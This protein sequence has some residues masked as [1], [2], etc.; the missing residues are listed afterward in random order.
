M[1]LVRNLCIFRES[2]RTNRDHIE[3]EREGEIVP[4]RSDRAD[5][6]PWD[7]LE[8]KEKEGKEGEEGRKEGRVTRER[9]PRSDDRTEGTV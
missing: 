8:Y 6:P 3:P 7:P 2:C 1:L 4:K 9:S 5:R